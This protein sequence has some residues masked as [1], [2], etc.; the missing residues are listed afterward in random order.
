MFISRTDFS[1][2]FK[3]YTKVT[4]KPAAEINNLTTC[5]LHLR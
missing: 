3:Q 5:F 1:I 2:V 4:I